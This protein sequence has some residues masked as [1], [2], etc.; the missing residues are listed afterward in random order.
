MQLRP[1]PDLDTASQA[2]PWMQL[3]RNS[4]PALRGL[5]SDPMIQPDGEEVGEHDIH[6]AKR[7]HGPQHRT[8]LI[9]EVRS[10]VK[11]MRGWGHGADAVVTWI[12]SPE[13]CMQRL[14]L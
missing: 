7:A 2:P 1:N 6:E 12:S 5:G 8:P 10:K 11:L 13:G 14:V 3:H 4:D 9:F